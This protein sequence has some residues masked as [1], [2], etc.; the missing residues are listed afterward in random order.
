MK[1]NR[2]FWGISLLV[3]GLGI[4]LMV[5]AGFN[6][7][8]PAQSQQQAAKPQ[9][10]VASP[11]ASF[12]GFRMEDAVINVAGTTGRAVVSITVE[13][14][15]KSQAM[16]GRRSYFN[17]PD[18]QSP[19]GEN[20][21]FRKF[22]DDFFGEVPQR[23]YKQIGVGS[24]VIIDPQGYILTNQHVVD[25]A[26]KAGILKEKLKARIPGLTWRSSRSTPKTFR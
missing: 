3:L 18:D 16:Q 25:E 2:I 26:D 21:P 12:E 19:F 7:S 9:A 13:H 22:F 1:A 8:S 24:G 4:G 15:S 14:V 6:F 17:S 11:A 5:S 10:A 23:E 20:D